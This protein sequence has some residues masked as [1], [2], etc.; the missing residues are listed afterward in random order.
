MNLLSLIVL[1]LLFLYLVLT[2]LMRQRGAHRVVALLLAFGIA[3]VAAGVTLDP[4][5]HPL[6]T[7][8]LIVWLIPAICILLILRLYHANRRRG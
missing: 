2:A 8:D 6:W 4:A 3:W 5:A 7:V 1:G